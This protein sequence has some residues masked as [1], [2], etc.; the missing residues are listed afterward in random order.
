M[1][2]FAS[3]SCDRLS[4]VSALPYY[5]ALYRT[6]VIPKSGAVLQLEGKKEK[7]KKKIKKEGAA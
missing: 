4:F 5:Y 3:G 1:N 7:K 6:A 2:S